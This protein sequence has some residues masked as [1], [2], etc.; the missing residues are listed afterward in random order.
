MENPLTVASRGRV[1]RPA[2]ENKGTRLNYAQHLECGL[3][4]AVLTSTS[5]HTASA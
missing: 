3:R 4:K 2:S 5:I 1:A